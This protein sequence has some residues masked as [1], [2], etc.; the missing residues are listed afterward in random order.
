[1]NVN[2]NELNSC[3]IIYYFPTLFIWNNLKASKAIKIGSEVCHYPGGSMIFW[4]LLLISAYLYVKYTV[5]SL[6][7]LTPIFLYVQEDSQWPLDL[8]FALNCH[9]GHGEITPWP[10]T[11]T[12]TLDYKS[13]ALPFKLTKWTYKI[14]L[15]CFFT[16]LDCVYNI[17]FKIFQILFSSFSWWF[18]EIDSSSRSWITTC[19]S[20][21]TWFV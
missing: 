12:A 2:R 14:Y 19:T 11:E 15:Y 9:I 18:E 3:S 4:W 21:A 6:S 20:S 5:F 7:G 13:E 8:M 1:M 16:S 17:T 10:R